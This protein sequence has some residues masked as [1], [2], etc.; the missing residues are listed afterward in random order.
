MTVS[1]MN[2]FRGSSAVEIPMVCQKV[3]GTDGNI[4]RVESPPIESNEHTSSRYTRRDQRTPDDTATLSAAERS[5][6]R[7]CS[8]SGHQERQQTDRPLFRMRNG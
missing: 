4:N 7:F 8:Q 2:Y 6:V 1:E 3:V 5:V